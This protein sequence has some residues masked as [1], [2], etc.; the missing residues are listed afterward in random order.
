MYILKSSII[1]VTKLILRSVTNF[2]RL[3]I[4]YKKKKVEIEADRKRINTFSK[5]MH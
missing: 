5:K 3:I 2:K 1:R 4:N